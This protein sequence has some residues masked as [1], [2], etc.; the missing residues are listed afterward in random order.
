MSPN[1]TLPDLI[2]GCASNLHAQREVPILLRPEE[3]PVAKTF[4]SSLGQV[5]CYKNFLSAKVKGTF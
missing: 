1:C 4:S 5:G 2:I 3:T